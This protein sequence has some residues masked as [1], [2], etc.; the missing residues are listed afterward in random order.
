MKCLAAYRQLAVDFLVHGFR[1]EHLHRHIRG[2]GRA[3]A[4]QAEAQ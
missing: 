3:V 4:E 2:A 1:G